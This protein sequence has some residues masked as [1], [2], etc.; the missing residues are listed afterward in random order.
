M[1]K[2]KSFWYLVLLGKEVQYTHNNCTI[3]KRFGFLSRHS[4]LDE[5]VENYVCEEYKISLISEYL[6][7]F[8]NP[9]ISLGA[10]KHLEIED[11][12]PVPK[13]QESSVTEMALSAAWSDEMKNHEHPML[14]RAMFQSFGKL[15]L[16]GTANAAI[17]VTVVGLQ[18]FFVTKLLEYI[19]TGNASVFGINSGMGLAFTLGILSVVGAFTINNSMYLLYCFGMAIR[20]ALIGIIFQKSLHISNSAKAKHSIGEVITL[21][22]V[23]VERVW[24]ACLLLVWLG[25]SPL[26]GVVAV[27]LLYMEMGHCALVVA[28]FLGVVMY[29]QEYVSKHIGNTRVE[30]VKH[31]VNRTKLTNEALQ[32]I[33]VVKIYAWEGAIEDRINAVR[34]KEVVLL[35]K[36]LILKITNTVSESFCWMDGC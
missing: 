13:Y 6:Y 7:S 30:L 3:M 14:T 16:Y 4:Q 19:S 24:M 26:L 8:M 28:A 10:C 33:R 25:M 27:I 17:F 36:Y 18:P 34:E 1:R 22:S 15:F 21:M 32:G 2:E 23:D 12:P 5:V 9:L 29:F 20:S 31:T 11:V 35:R